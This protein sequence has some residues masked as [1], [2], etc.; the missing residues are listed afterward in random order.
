MEEGLTCGR[1]VGSGSRGGL[2]SRQVGI[3]RE[4]KG[5]GQRGERGMAQQVFVEYVG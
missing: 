2:R 4:K 3:E 1:E 5:K